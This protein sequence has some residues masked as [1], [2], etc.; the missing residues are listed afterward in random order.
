ML[1]G[2]SPLETL[3][4]LCVLHAVVDYGLSTEYVAFAKSHKRSEGKGVWPFV[5]LAHSLMHG[6]AVFFAT[7]NIFFGCGETVLHAITDYLKS[8]GKISYGIDQAIHYATKVLW[9]ILLIVL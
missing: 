3:F 9:V 2:L 7:G 4:V 5:L 8:D 6:G 1:Y